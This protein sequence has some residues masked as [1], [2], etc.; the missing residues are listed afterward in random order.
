[1]PVVDA[2]PPPV[3]WR[4]QRRI[5]IQSAIRLVHRGNGSGT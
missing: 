3:R 5:E 4:Q 2:E 1:M